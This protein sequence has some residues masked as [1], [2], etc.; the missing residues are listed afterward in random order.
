MGRRGH[1][2]RESGDLF[3]ASALARI[4]HI[5]VAASTFCCTLVRRAIA[6]LSTSVLNNPTCSV[7]LGYLDCQAQSA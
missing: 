1:D 2:A 3:C 5:L 4:A 6:R 7:R